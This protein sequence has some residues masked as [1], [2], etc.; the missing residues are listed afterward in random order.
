MLFRRLALALL[1]MLFAVDVYR[2]AAQALAVDH[3]LYTYLSWTSMHLL[4]VALLLAS[5]TLAIIVTGLLAAHWRFALLYPMD[6]TGL[7]LIPLVPLAAA[8]HTTYYRDW[9]YCRSLKHR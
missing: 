4:A 8:F 7:H 6:R 3:F 5:S 1:V 2:A 9:P